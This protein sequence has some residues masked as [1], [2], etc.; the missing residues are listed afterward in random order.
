MNIIIFIIVVRLYFY[1]KRT[2]LMVDGGFL[3]PSLSPSLGTGGASKTDEFSEMFNSSVFQAPPVPYSH[4]QH[5]SGSYC[6]LFNWWCWRVCKY[7]SMI[8]SYVHSHGDQA[9]KLGSA[10]WQQYD[11][12]KYQDFTHW[13]WVVRSTSV[14][15]TTVPPTHFSKVGL[16][17][18]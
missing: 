7:W 1:Y 10:R 18:M 17:T 15:P 4:H 13:T 9:S 16:T 6:N 12:K 11:L 8:T 14:I 2:M 5:Q 3:P